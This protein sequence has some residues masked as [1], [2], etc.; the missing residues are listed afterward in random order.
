VKFS[1]IYADPPWQFR[2]KAAAGKRGAGF[3]YPVMSVKDIC[4]LRPFVDTLCNRNVVLAMWWVA[5]QPAEALKV[6]DAWGFRL[7]TMKLF[8]W[9]KLTKHGKD[10]FGMGNWSRANT[11]D[12]L[13][14]TRGPA[15]HK[16]LRSR[17][18]PQ[19][20]HAPRR[21]HSQKP[22]EARTRLEQMF[23]GTARIELFA[24]DIFPGWASWGL[25]IDRK[26]EIYY[27][28]DGG[29]V[30]WPLMEESE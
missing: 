24:R 26:G 12:C 10:H 8:T 3:K 1:V 2:D 29:N 14:A 27:L 25:D 20:I 15:A 23:P 18:I 30:A 4:A 6:L 17:A 16:L 7:R 11:E 9:H 21:L 28:K 19:L 5:S 13:L 22:D